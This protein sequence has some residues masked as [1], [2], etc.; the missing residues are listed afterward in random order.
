MERT[1]SDRKSMG[2]RRMAYYIGIDLG[3]S[4]VKMLMMDERGEIIKIIF[5][6][7][8]IFFPQLGWAE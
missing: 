4:A 8:P 5:K 1:V 3:T 6:E 7:Y 2:V